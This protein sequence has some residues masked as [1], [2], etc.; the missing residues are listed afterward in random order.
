MY[1]HLPNL[2]EL[3][4]SKKL[5]KRYGPVSAREFLDEGYLPEAL[6]NFLMLLG[7]NPGTDRE[8]YTLDEFTKEF[9]INKIHKTDLVAFDRQKLLWMNG[10]Y[11]QNMPTGSLKRR[12]EEYYKEDA[13]VLGVL[14]SAD[15]DALLE[16]AKTRM[17]TL[18]DFRNLVIPENV[19]LNSEEKEVAQYMHEVFGAITSWNK[20]TIL[21]GMRAVL[22]EKKVKGSLLYKILTGREQGLP[23]PES[24]E[25]LGKEKTLQKLSQMA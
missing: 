1:A 19:Q 16:L 5:S 9:D 7:W 15:G 23:L 3:G 10:Y 21:E 11:I 6:D 4:A 2:K 13:E 25:L 18:K 22:K 8:M 20:D 17:K 14:A 24:L 12:L